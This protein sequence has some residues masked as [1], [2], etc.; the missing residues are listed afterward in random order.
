[1]SHVLGKEVKAEDE[2][3]GLSSSVEDGMPHKKTKDMCIP[4]ATEDVN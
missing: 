3:L 4:M 2:M 1:V